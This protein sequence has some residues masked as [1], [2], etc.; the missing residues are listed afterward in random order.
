MWRTLCRWWIPKGKYLSLRSALRLWRWAPLIPERGASP[1]APLRRMWSWSRPPV[2]CARAS[3]KKRRLRFMV[4]QPLTPSI[5]SIVVVMRFNHTPPP[6]TQ[7]AQ[8]P[9]PGDLEAAMNNP[10]EGCRLVIRTELPSV[11]PLVLRMRACPHERFSC[12]APPALIASRRDR[13]G[14]REFRMGRSPLASPQFGV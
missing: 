10:T 13:V 8:A 5:V 4:S 14:S 3:R 7:P 9:R 1:H 11:P 6:Q 12:G 2:E